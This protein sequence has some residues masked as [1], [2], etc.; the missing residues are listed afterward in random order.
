MMDAGTESVEWVTQEF[1][2]ADLRDKRLDRRLVKTAEQLAKSPSSPINEA[3]GTWAS[4]QAAYRLFNNP[5][6]S[7]L[8]ILK[9][10][11]EAT[12]TRMSGCGGAVLAIQDTVFFSY[13][14][15]VKTRGLGP[16][17]KSNAAHDRG[18]IMHNALAFTTSGVPLGIVS[19]SIW[20]R[21]EIPEEDYQEKI[22]RLQV[23]AI[24][25]KES[26]KWLIALRETVER[27]PAGV[28]V[29]TVAD[30]ESD[31]FEFLTQAKELRAKYL[32]RART[33]RKL[34]PEDSAGCARML[35]ALSDA[36][37]LGTMRVEVPGNGSRKARSAS[38][39]VRVA[40]VTIQAPPR[41]GAHAKASGSSEPVTVTLIGATEQSPPA[42][43]DSISWVLLTNLPVKDFESATEKVQ[44]YARRWGI[45]IWHKVL[46]SGCKVEDCMLEEAE[47]LK[48]YLT[49]FS[50][51]GV[52]L[53][54]VTYLARVHPDLP[55]T[56]VFSVEEVEALHIRVTK[57][58]PPADPA[59]TLREVVRMLGK[60]GGHLG[61]KGDGE[62]GV[63]VLWRGW[64]SLYE[65]VE[66][67]RA[68]KQFLGLGNSS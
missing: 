52:R 58:L 2:R 31:F 39:E 62:P 55:A 33:D 64:T 48:R 18:L 37:A 7:A 15:H 63:T 56:E 10:H 30:R 12:A 50:I 38:I 49:L 54:H 59:P 67:L 46:K 8:G 34:V 3:C 26:S 6:A 65:T 40:E 4:T 61:R 23:T 45:E 60:L 36:P 68:H 11:W 53:M 9:P 66:T 35:E 32:I 19:Q 57:A 16:I 20:A 43:S 1:A 47:R 22:E 44:W 17:G 5:K 28:P 24:E 42:G 27:A 14:S 29:V 21:G 13:G 41:R 51:I 25:E